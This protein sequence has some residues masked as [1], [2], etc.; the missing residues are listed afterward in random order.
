MP[1]IRV[2]EDAKASKPVKF[3]ERLGSSCLNSEQGRLSSY[4]NI[5]HERC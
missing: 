1:Q 3:I 4:V 5:I 2:H